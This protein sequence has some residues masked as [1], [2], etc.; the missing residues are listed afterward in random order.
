MT[1]DADALFEKQFS[2]FLG[3]GD[4]PV[5]DKKSDDA[6]LDESKAAEQIVE[7]PTVEQKA[8][9]PTAADRAKKLGWNPDKEDFEAKTGKEW[10]TASQFLRQR[11]M[12]DEIHRRGQEA[13]QLRREMESL[14]KTVNERFDSMTKTEQDAKLSQLTQN[15]KQAAIDQDFDMLDALITERDN[16]LKSAPA[17]QADSQ[18]ESDS[19]LPYI[20]SADE[21]KAAVDKWKSENRWFEK[22]TPKIQAE[23]RQFELEYQ[24]MFENPSVADSL[25]YAAQ[26]MLEKY[27]VLAA[28]A[29]KLKAP[30]ASPRQAERPASTSSV[31][32]SQLDP[33][34]RALL[35]SL[36]SRGF[37]KTSADEQAFLKDALGA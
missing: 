5:D 33:A 29:V 3:S 31:S 32:A 19:E 27:P 36:K 15:I 13:K 18:P 28:H 6:K 8:A 16:L 24:S 17:K 20:E 34:S 14:K 35:N 12:A 26:K 1:T 23:A 30:D 21:V 2:A 7:T 22:S 9:E 11:E 10:T 25:A 37:I 4:Q